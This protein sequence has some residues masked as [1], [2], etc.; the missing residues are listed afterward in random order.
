M[1]FKICQ[2]RKLVVINQEMPRVN[3]RNKGTTESKMIDE[4]KRF[5]KIQANLEA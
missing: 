3:T 4:D 1:Q 2:E 5:L